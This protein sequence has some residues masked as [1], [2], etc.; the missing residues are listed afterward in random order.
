[1]PKGIFI[2]G[3]GTDVGKTLVTAGLVRF[4]QRNGFEPLAVK[5]VQSGAIPDGAGGFDSPDGEVYK[6]AGAE[7]DVSLQCPFIFRGACSPHLAAIRDGQKIEASL[8]ADKVREI[9]G[10]GFLLVEGAGGVMVP[11]NDHE[12]M[13]DLM[14]E[15]DYPVVVVSANILGSINHALLTLEVL[16]QAGITIAG[17]I[18]TETIQEEDVPGMRRDNIESIEKFSHVPVLASLNWIP[19]Y[20]IYN[21]AMWEEVDRVFDFIDMDLLKKRIGIAKDDEIAS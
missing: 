11:L 12:T 19:D 13:L 17:V 7:W 1:M 18:T 9:E 6:T 16:K 2:T 20:D 15:L 4:F 14:K 5:P 21:A 10:N 8:I 3:T